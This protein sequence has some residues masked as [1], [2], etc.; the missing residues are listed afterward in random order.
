MRCVGI[1]LVGM[2][3]NWRHFL[4]GVVSYAFRM[5]PNEIDDNDSN[6]FFDVDEEEEDEEQVNSVSKLRLLKGNRGCIT[7]SCFYF[8]VR[9]IN[10]PNGPLLLNLVLST[11]HLFRAYMYLMS[12]CLYHVHFPYKGITW[13]APSIKSLLNTNDNNWNLQWCLLKAYYVVF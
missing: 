6:D 13:G 7:Q 9:G 12:I 3:W 4:N 5:L 8:L 10:S 2:K 1:E 11:F